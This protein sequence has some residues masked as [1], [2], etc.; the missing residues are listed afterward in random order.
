MDSIIAK[1]EAA[2][3]NSGD[4]LSRNKVEVLA[5]TALAIWCLWVPAVTILA[6]AADPNVFGAIR[7]WQ[8]ALPIFFLVP[9]LVGRGWSMAAIAILWFWVAGIGVALSWL[10]ALIALPLFP[11]SLLAGLLISGLAY[12]FHAKLYR[13]ISSDRDKTAAA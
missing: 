13:H 11:F 7:G 4:N 1:L 6:M 12:G 10:L 2:C 5:K 3:L 8:L 9:R